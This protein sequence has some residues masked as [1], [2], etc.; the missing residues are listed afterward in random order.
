MLEHIVV[1]IQLNLNFWVYHDRRIQ[2]S[3]FLSIVLE[4]QDSHFRGDAVRCRADEQEPLGQEV[5]DQH[6]Y[7]E[8]WD[9]IYEHVPCDDEIREYK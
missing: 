2:G 9:R 7:V 3:V 8:V 4:S 6:Q 1:T 5:W